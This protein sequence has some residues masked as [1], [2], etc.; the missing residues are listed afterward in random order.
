MVDLMTKRTK[1]KTMKN[2]FNIL[3]N[4]KAIENPAKINLK[5]IKKFIQGNYYKFILKFKYFRDKEENKSRLEQIQWRRSQIK[6]LS[7][8]CI[9][10]GECF[11][12]C[13]IEG[14]I[15]ANPGCNEKGKCFPEMMSA[16]FWNTYKIENNIKI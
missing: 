7:P 10:K 5:N 8:I 11:C 3:F 4:R 12:G 1:K 13:D 9:Q 6:I 16:Y 14:L 15:H 2:I